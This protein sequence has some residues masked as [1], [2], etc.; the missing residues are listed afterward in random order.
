MQTECLIWKRIVHLYGLPAICSLCL[1][2]ARAGMKLCEEIIYQL[3]VSI[4]IT[5]Q[6]REM[7]RATTQQFWEEKLCG[8]KSN[9]IWSLFHP[10]SPTMRKT[11]LCVVSKAYCNFGQS[12]DKCNQFIVYKVFKVWATGFLWFLALGCVQPCIFTHHGP[13]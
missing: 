9:F 4:L 11:S 8:S 5:C 3:S 12:F 1:F 6:L 13:E 7:F 10:A 2:P